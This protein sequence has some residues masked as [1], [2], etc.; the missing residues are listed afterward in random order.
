MCYILTPGRSVA[1]HYTTA[2]PRQLPIYEYKINKL[3]TY[4]RFMCGE[5][6]ER[7]LY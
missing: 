3:Q 5:I 2:A 6:T 1:V 7:T 4:M